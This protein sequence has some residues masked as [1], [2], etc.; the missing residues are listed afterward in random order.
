ME[1][2]GLATW[3][4]TV[5]R[6]NNASALRIAV[7][8]RNVLE[9]MTEHANDAQREAIRTLLGPCETAIEIAIDR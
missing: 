6:E 1:P 3:L 5:S 9:E 8:W 7:K 4:L 2:E